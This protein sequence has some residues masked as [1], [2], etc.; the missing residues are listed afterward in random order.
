MKTN[1]GHLLSLNSNRIKNL[2]HISL[3]IFV[4]LGVLG[5]ASKSF[6]YDPTPF[7]P[8]DSYSKVVEYTYKAE[9]TMVSNQGRFAL[10]HLCALVGNFKISVGEEITWKRAETETLPH[11]DTEIRT[12][13]LYGVTSSGQS[14]TLELG[15]GDNIHELYTRCFLNFFQIDRSQSLG[16]SNLPPSTENVLSGAHRS[17]SPAEQRD[18]MANK[19]IRHVSGTD[20]S[21]A[22][23]FASGELQ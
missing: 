16:L 15:Y 19:A 7:D 12:P 10:N 2:A 1:T 4:W 6:A 9:R 23:Q 20:R 11:A 21:I 17:E 3:C 8:N 5:Y 13:R 22:T 18:L 14:I